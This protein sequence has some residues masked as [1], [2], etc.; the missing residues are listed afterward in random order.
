MRSIRN[1]CYVAPAQKITMSCGSMTNDNNTYFVNPNYPSSYDGMNSCQITLVKSHPDV[2]QYRLDFP[3][4]NIMGPETTNNV[5]TY[6]QFIVSGGNPVPTICGNN[7]GNHMYIDTGVGQTNPIT[8]TFVTSGSSFP[9]AWK[10]RISQIRCST[11]YRAEEGCL[12]YFTGVSGQ[13][14]SFNYDPTGGLQLSNQDY[15]I[16]IRMER[17]FCGI[18]YMACIDDAQVMM[19][20][21][22]AAVGQ[23][24]RSNAF[25]L[26][27]N[28]QATQIASMTGVSCLTDWLAIPCA[29]N[30]GRMSTAPLICVDRL[31]GG[32]F[33]AETQNLNSSPV[34]S[35][36]KPFRLIFHT[37]NIEAPGDV[38]NRGFCLNYV[39]QPC[40]TK[41]R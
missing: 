30:S 19:P 23:I 28:T 34:I 20:A 22:V 1:R 41:L 5:C 15:S 21:G 14:K 3:Q 31:C 18:Q 37:D 2:C 12:Q 35:T 24:M 25:T 6:D 33:N 26:T 39:Q 16:C 27:G 36:V 4:F 40:T 11:I 17:N 13:I 7:N 8:L 38:G 29:T 9:R 10:V 32:T